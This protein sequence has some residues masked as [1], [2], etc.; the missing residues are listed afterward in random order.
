MSSN[1]IVTNQDS[2]NISFLEERNKD[3]EMKIKE[4]I[5]TNKKDI[6]VMTVEELDKYLDNTVSN[7]RIPEKQSSSFISSRFINLNLQDPIRTK[8][9]KHILKDSD[10]TDKL[11]KD[12]KE[13]SSKKKRKS[14]LES[15]DKIFIRSKG[16]CN[17]L[18]KSHKIPNVTSLLLSNTQFCKIQ[19]KNDNFSR[20]CNKEKIVKLNE[21]LDD[22]MK[23]NDINIIEIKN[24]EEES[25]LQKENKDLKNEIV[26]LKE[27][28]GRKDEDLKNYKDLFS[29]NEK[30]FKEIEE[31]LRNEVKSLHNDIIF[32]KSSL[33]TQVTTTLLR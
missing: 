19:D 22:K 7:I 15:S 25:I 14:D 30:R 8:F 21:F 10:K 5:L 18:F 17:N 1:R 9:E 6:K 20:K 4:E 26:Q 2:L 23:E 27:L 11:I 24:K 33:D 28:I 29:N 12:F 13:S 16:S 32:L 3:N 31:K